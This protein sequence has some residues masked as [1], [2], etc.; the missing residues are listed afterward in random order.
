MNLSLNTGAGN[1]VHIYVGSSV[2][3]S[4]HDFLEP[5]IHA[6]EK[7][8][9][10]VDENTSDFCLPV[11]LSQTGD[12]RNAEVMRTNAG[13]KN[14]SLET[15]GWIWNSLA[16]RGA[17]R[18]S[19]LINLGGGVITDLGGFV[20]SIYKRG[21]PFV[22]IPTTLLAMTD[23]SVGGKTG[24]NLGKIKN[25]LG[26]FHNPEAIFIHTGFLETLDMETILDGLAEVLKMA[27]VAD[28][29]LWDELSLLTFTGL[30]GIPFRDET[31]VKLVNRCIS[32]KCG[33]VEKDF[34]DT[35]TREILNF[36]HTVGHAF[37]SLSMQNG[38]NSMSHGR[39]VAL[40]MICES[41]LSFMKTGLK[42][43]ER[44]FIVRM[45]LSV[46]RHYKLEE[47][48]LSFLTECMDQDKKQSVQGTRFPLLESPGKAVAGVICNSS[49]VLESIDFYRN[50]QP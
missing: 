22:H 19:L 40:G 45:I 6:K 26:T 44:D 31:W 18:H 50:L 36:G 21:I 39:A 24:I 17:T 27:L 16:E 43:S 25:Q 9:I 10:L 38:M 30:T 14:K 28:K 3:A 8:F 32:L 34:R 11:L 29:D 15:A 2:F 13:E 49:E 35:G 20:A 4:L 7:I 47:N 48:D 23:A 37:E 42:A 41:Q 33:I 46:Y 12:L 5:F 1:L